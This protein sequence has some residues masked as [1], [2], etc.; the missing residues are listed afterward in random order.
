MKA[1]RSSAENR[2]RLRQAGF[3]V[4]PP[5]LAVLK[6]FE[7]EHEHLSPDE[8]LERGRKVYPALGRATVYR[9]LDL[10]TGLGV[11]RPL[12]L[13]DGRPCFTRVAEG[14]HHLVCSGCD[15]I[16][17]F[18]ED[19]IGRIARRLSRELGFEVRSHLLEFYGLCGKCKTAK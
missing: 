9:T 8:V 3:R 13:G 14:H 15:R 6:V 5:R 12:Y 17:E 16:T 7:A 18:D 1:R 10:L 19:G 4:T 11:L 2:Q